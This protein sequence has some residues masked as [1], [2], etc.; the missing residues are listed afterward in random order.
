MPPFHLWQVRKAMLD[1]TLYTNPAYK[2]ALRQ[3]VREALA[4]LAKNG[5][6]DM[7]LCVVS[8]GFGTVLATDYFS[9]LEANP[10]SRLAA[11]PLE[12]GEA[13]ARRTSPCRHA[14]PGSVTQLRAL[15]SG[16]TLAFFCTLGSPLQKFRK[17]QKLC[18]WKASKS[19][20]P[21]SQT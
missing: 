5:H 14:S 1:L 11:S 21:R 17:F 15:R 2:A 4:A 8:H 20:W 9:Q 18:V 19:G 6:G 3:S 13:H 12:R 7:P 16:N 10:P